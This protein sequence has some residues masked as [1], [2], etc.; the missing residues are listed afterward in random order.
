LG[1]SVSSLDFDGK[2]YFLTD[3]VKL[4]GLAGLTIGFAKATATIDLGTGPETSSASESEFG[5][6]FGAGADFYLSDSMYLNGQ[7][8]YNT[9]LEQLAINLG[10]GFNL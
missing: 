6:N 8:K 2:Y 3:N 9:P 1:I 4:Y 5:V 7:L 10:I